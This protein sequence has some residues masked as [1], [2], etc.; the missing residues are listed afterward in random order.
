[1]NNLFFQIRVIIP[2]EKWQVIVQSS[3][4]KGINSVAAIYDFTRKNGGYGQEFITGHNNPEIN[5][6]LWVYMKAY[7]KG[8]LGQ[9]YFTMSDIEFTPC[10]R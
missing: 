10:P 7:T 4:D 5:E 2:K 8:V 3:N 9:D 1:M 6:K